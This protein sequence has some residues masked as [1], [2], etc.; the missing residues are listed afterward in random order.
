MT[1]MSPDSRKMTT[2]RKLLIEPMNMTQVF[3]ILLKLIDRLEG[4]P[5][6]WSV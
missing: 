1:N 6:Y 3:T 2:V 4:D 5:L